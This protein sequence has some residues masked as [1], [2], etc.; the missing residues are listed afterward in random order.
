MNLIV[1]AMVLIIHFVR[2]GC[3]DSYF[4]ER[5]F[6][7]GTEFS[8]AIQESDL[9]MRVGNIDSRNFL[10]IHGT[11]DEMVHQQ[12]SLILTKALTDQAIGFR[13]QVSRDRFN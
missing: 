9:S 8:R 1:V 10:L 3:I 6:K 11:A 2:F 7:T 5:Y 12:H 4:T 13:H